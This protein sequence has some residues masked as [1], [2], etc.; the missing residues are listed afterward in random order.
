ML[1]KLEVRQYDLN[2]RVFKTK[3]NTSTFQRKFD[4][5][6]ELRFSL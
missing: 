6:R 5:N 1:M 2:N 4:E 3:A